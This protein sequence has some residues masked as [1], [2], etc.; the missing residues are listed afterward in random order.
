MIIVRAVPAPLTHP[1]RVSLHPT[2]PPPATDFARALTPPHTPP[3]TNLMS[4]NT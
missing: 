1:L 4:H 3:V 2:A